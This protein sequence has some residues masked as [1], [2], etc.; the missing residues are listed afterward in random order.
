MKEMFANV[1]N[2]M[3]SGN[4]GKNEVVNGIRDI[5]RQVAG[6]IVPNIVAKEQNIVGAIIDPETGWTHEAL[7]SGNG[8]GA[9]NW[10]TPIMDADGYNAIKHPNPNNPEAVK[11]ALAIIQQDGDWEERFYSPEYLGKY[12]TQKANQ[13]RQLLSDETNPVKQALKQKL[14]I[15]VVTRM[16][17][18]AASLITSRD[19]VT[20]QV[21]NNLVD[22]QGLAML[23]YN[24]VELFQRVS[25]PN[26]V[27]KY[28]QFGDV[29]IEPNV[30]EGVIIETTKTEMEEV[31]YKIGKNVGAVGATWE[32]QL[33][34][35]QGDPYGVITSKIATK[36]AQ[37]RNIQMAAIIETA[38]AVA[39]LDVGAKT[40]DSSTNDPADFLAS[41][42]DIIGNDVSQTAF[43]GQVGSVFIS[44]RKAFM[45][46]L[47]NTNTKGLFAP[48]G[49]MILDNQLASGIPTIP[50]NA[51]WATSSLVSATKLWVLDPRATPAMFGPSQ[52]SEHFDNR[53]L[54]KATYYFDAFGTALVSPN[55]IRE[56]TGVVS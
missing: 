30:E 2:D 35:T 7:M 54:S 3:I 44:G 31:K 46:F 37:Q 26:L 25:V 24:L 47:S 52:R 21:N 6:E 23:R 18:L 19:F 16:N 5:V 50:V 4:A 41:V 56:I 20:L 15:S 27:A 1:T 29:D 36:L 40:G 34:V 45:K 32:S 14:P 53:N 39:G 38:T 55:A 48:N 12:Q 51:R 42:L 43:D 33:M 22:T 9:N 49:T 10:G 11:A 13:L 17:P 28:W 8:V